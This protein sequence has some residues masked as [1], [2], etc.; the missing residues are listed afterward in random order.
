M[1]ELVVIESFPI[2]PTLKERDQRATKP[3]VRQYHPG[4]KQGQAG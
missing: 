2:T 3:G 1:V 4:A